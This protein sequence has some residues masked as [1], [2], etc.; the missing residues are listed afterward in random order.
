MQEPEPAEDP[1]PGA[2]AQHL[3]W[4]SLGHTLPALPRSRLRKRLVR[5]FQ[6]PPVCTGSVCRRPPTLASS[7]Y[8]RSRLLG[9]VCRELASPSLLVRRR[10]GRSSPPDS[11]RRSSW[12][13]RRRKLKLF[14]R[15]L[16]FFLGPEPLQPLP[17]KMFQRRLPHREPPRRKPGLSAACGGRA[18][19]RKVM[20]L[21]RGRCA[22][23]GPS[24]SASGLCLRGERSRSSSRRR[25]RARAGGG[26]GSSAP[27]SPF[28]AA[29][30]L[31]G[32]RRCCC[33]APSA[34][35]TAGTPCK[36]SDSQTLTA[37]R[38]LGRG[39]PRPGPAQRQP[40]AM[41][42]GGAAPWP[43]RSPP[44]ARGSHE[45]PACPGR[46]RRRQR[47]A[48]PARP[49]TGRGRDGDG[50]GAGA[51]PPAAPSAG[52]DGTESGARA[53]AAAP[54]RGGAGLRPRGRE[55][56]AGPCHCSAAHSA[57]G[58]ARNRERRRCP[59]A[60]TPPRRS[61][62][63]ELARSPSERRR[64]SGAEPARAPPGRSPGAEPARPLQV[65]AVRCR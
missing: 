11:E 9:Q 3:P 10:A 61:P 28:P 38:G 29:Q 39:A 52:T 18:L 48:G 20:L 19:G 13:R 26:G 15:E 24:P 16:K 14:R 2:Q 6:S 5:S 49:G 51:A 1:R 32:R 37:R 34:A 50:A 42:S 35:W 22:S 60:R 62:G 55:S 44:P 7:G 46:A 43:P 63:P 8:S 40:S 23:S 30:K 57:R 33:A 64:A 54:S 53:A 25:P 36:S 58:G 31:L 65:L 59:A 47:G 17:P 12:P 41:V 45:A 56:S 4:A 21:G 27:G